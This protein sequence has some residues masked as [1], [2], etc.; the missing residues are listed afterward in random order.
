[1]SNQ[2]N[3][4]CPIC[5]ADNMCTDFTDGFKW[6]RAYCN[7]CDCAGPEV[8]TGYEESLDA[9]WRTEARKQFADVANEYAN[10]LLA[11]DNNVPCKPSDRCG[12]G[13]KAILTD[14]TVEG[15]L[16]QYSVACETCFIGL[17]Y[18]FDTP[19]DAWA[20]W[21]RA[22]GTPSGAI[23]PDAGEMDPNGDEGARE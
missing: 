6:G 4:P 15:A 9:P 1:M 17:P 16:K 19:D 14:Y 21:R 8:R 22:M 10:K 13:G 2:S 3:Y 7:S 11:E 5:G 12:C 18:G 20:A 23:G